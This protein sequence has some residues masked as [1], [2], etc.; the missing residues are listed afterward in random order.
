M[1]LRKPE[2]RNCHDKSKINKMENRKRVKQQI[3]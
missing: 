2:G 1:E 3:H